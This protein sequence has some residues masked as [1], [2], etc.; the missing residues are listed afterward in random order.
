MQSLTPCPFCG[1]DIEPDSWYCDQCGN[2]LKKCTNCGNLRRGAFCPGCGAPTKPAQQLA[3]KSVPS[4]DPGAGGAA[5]AAAP[6]GA[7]ANPIGPITPA[8]APSAPGVAPSAPTGTSLPN[9]APQ[10]SALVCQAMGVT[11]P[12]QPGALIGRVQGNYAHMLGPRFPSLSGRHARLDFN[13]TGWTITDIGSSYGT[14]VNG[15]A[16]APNMPVPLNIGDMVVF[17]TCYYFTVQ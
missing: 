9:T 4:T 3:L 11:L 2:E 16:C 8:S 14:T 6:T 12:L 15:R 17:A 10:P 13:G 7:N 5:G 1:A